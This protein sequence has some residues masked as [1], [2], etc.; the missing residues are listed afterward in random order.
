MFDTLVFPLKTQL[1]PSGSIPRSPNKLRFHHNV[2]LTVSLTV[3]TPPQ[4]VSMVID[5]GSELSWL[6]CNKTRNYPT[7]FDP[8]RSSS[9]SP[10]PCSSSICINRT[11]DFSIPTSCD[12]DNLCP[13]SL[14][15][16]PRPPKEISLPIFSKRGALLLRLW[17]SDAW[18]R[19]STPTRM[20]TQ[21]MR[22]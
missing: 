3:G 20:K 17:S 4:N 1:I 21:R 16:T 11:R 2:S 7:I 5:T 15:R 13:L 14:T 12:S 8:A 19:S 10:I 9:Y 6:P 22:V 18:T